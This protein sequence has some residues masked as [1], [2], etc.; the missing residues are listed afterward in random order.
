[1]AGDL[2]RIAVAGMV[3]WGYNPFIIMQRRTLLSVSI[4]LNAVLA[5]TLAVVAHRN[6]PATPPAPEP[7]PHER[8]PAPKTGPASVVADKQQ[9]DWN[10]L[11]SSDYA[12]YISN[13]RAIHCPEQTI[14]DIIEADVYQVYTDKQAALELQ[15]DRAGRDMTWWGPGGVGGNSVEY[16]KEIQALEPERKALLTSLLGPGWEVDE[17]V[18]REALSLGGAALSALSLETRHKLEGILDGLARS[19]A[20]VMEEEGSPGGQVPDAA[21]SA[22]REEEV[23]RLERAARQEIAALLTPEQFEEFELRNSDTAANLRSSIPG[24]FHT[25]P[26]EFRKLFQA[27]TKY[28]TSLEE[29]EGR[30]DPASDQRREELLAQLDSAKRA[31]LGDARFE[32]LKL[33]DDS[34]YQEA[35]RLAEQYNAAP[36]TVQVLREINQAAAAETGR[37][38]DNADLSALQRAIATKRLELGQL[39]AQARALGQSLPDAAPA[40]PMPPVENVTAPPPPA[41]APAGATYIVRAGD[42][43]VR[44]ARQNNL[45]TEALRNANPGLQTDQLRIGQPILIPAAPAPP[46]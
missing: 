30:E 31:A 14:R 5:A 2:T 42:S 28:N 19:T 3:N 45:T 8:E 13:L 27:T 20:K 43:L 41:P 10:Q 21:P 39:E 24:E 40:Q 18:Q 35:K 23:A 1:M 26:E 15:Q 34:S 4:C 36:D 6:T 33:L 46:Q 9:F 7:A 44:I 32:E 22:D 38:N 25:T 29:L 16:S 37:L 12:I 11:E 17:P